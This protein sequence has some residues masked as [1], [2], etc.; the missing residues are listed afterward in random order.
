MSERYIMPLIRNNVEDIRGPEQTPARQNGSLNFLSAYP[1]F[2][3][4]EELCK[5]G[6]TSEFHDPSS[7]SI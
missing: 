1:G 5:G 3:D 4:S 7:I 6:N 2:G